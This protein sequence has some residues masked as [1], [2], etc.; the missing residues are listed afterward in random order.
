MER[1]YDETAYHVVV[2]RD[3]EDV[4]FWLADVTGLDGG[5]TYARS[6]AALDRY[7]REVIVLA[8]DLP[9]DAEDDLRLTWEYHTG[10]PTVDDAAAGLRSRRESAEVEARRLAE[11][12]SVLACQLVAEGRYSLR[13]AAALLA[14]SPSRIGQLAPKRP[15]RR[16]PRPEALSA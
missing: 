3:P 11:E 9:D 6:L 1:Q 5:H 2:T 14:V 16:R 10:D 7:V 12:T 4:R 8:A 13:D 15:A